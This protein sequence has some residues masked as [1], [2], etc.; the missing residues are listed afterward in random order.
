MDIKSTLLKFK[1]I[2]FL[3]LMSFVTF[4]LV[5]A[6]NQFKDSSE[7]VSAKENTKELNSVEIVSP[8]LNE[9][10]S[11]VPEK[12]Q[13]DNKPIV[14]STIAS[15]ECS[16]SVIKIDSYSVCTRGGSAEIDYKDGYRSG[17]SVSKNSTVELVEVNIPLELFSGSGVKDSNRKITTKTPI[18]KPAGEIGRAHV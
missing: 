4:T 10:D 1:P 16:A 5:W 18:Y 11:A 12:V 13:E 9:S 6:V 3:L 2:F 14:L 15:S 8:V 7:F 17:T